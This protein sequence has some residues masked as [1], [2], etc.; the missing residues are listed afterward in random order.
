MLQLIYD[1]QKEYLRF[2]FVIS[3]NINVL[4]NL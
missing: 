1:L 3:E 4:K 2:L